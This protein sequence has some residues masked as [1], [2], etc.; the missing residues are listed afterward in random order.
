MRILFSSCLGEWGGGEHWMLSTALGLRERGHHVELA[1]A[2]GSELARRAGEAGLAVTEL[3]FHGDLDPLLSWRYWRL[4]RRRRID[5]LCLNMDK[6]LRVAGPAARLAGAAV[7]P[8]RGSESPLGGKVSHRLAY[9]KVATGVIANSLATRAT[10]LASAPWLTAGKVRVIANGIDVGRYA[11]DPDAR[12]AVRAEAGAGPRTPVLGM[13]G[14]LTARKNHLVVVRQL[15][16]LRA[17]YPDLQLWIV[18]EGP[19]RGALLEAARAAGAGDVLRLLGFRDNVPRLLQG[20]DVFC[21]PARREG[22]GY[23]V[24]EA[25]AAGKPVVVARASNL[26]EIVPDGEAGLLRDP[27][28][29]EG[30]R[31]AVAALL[32]DAALAGRLAEAGRRRAGELYSSRRMLD[33]VEA[34]FRELLRP[35]AGGGDASV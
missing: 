25:M 32:E 23:A 26:P 6:V 30:W 3:V 35:A 1:C 5:L 31:E 16:A 8:R 7:V 10:L 13:V 27:D 18:G 17:A 34:Y 29:G 28:D 33:E 24:V 11:P 22:F 21:H 9:L 4:C 2:R 15:G 12:A 14:E 19:E 20:I